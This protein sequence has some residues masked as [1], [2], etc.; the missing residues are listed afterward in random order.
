MVSNIFKYILFC[1]FHE[2]N[3]KPRYRRITV[4]VCVNYQ[5]INEINIYN[6]DSEYKNQNINPSFFECGYYGVS[7]QNI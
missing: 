3:I 7:V 1:Y 4:K 5:S 6:E 2:I